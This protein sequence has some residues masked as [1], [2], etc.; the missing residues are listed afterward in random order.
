MLWRVENLRESRY[1]P[2]PDQAF[3]EIHRWFQADRGFSK[4]ANGE[5]P[6]LDRDQAEQYLAD[7]MACCLAAWEGI[8]P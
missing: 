5:P 3:D 1:G 4:G 6:F 8:L 2:E 7:L